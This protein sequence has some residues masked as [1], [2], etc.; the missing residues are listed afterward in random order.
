SIGT[1][2]WVFLR[3]RVAGDPVLNRS[4]RNWCHHARKDDEAG[5]TAVF[6]YAFVSHELD[7]RP[8]WSRASSVQEKNCLS[9]TGR[10][11]LHRI[12]RPVGR[13]CFLSCGRPSRARP[14]ARLLN[15]RSLPSYYLRPSDVRGTSSRRA[16]CCALYLALRKQG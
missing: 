9:T 15:C 3:K 5:I 12:S 11:G 16:R 14:R 8:N 7:C 6:R 2:S 10:A 13:N 4:V 1:A